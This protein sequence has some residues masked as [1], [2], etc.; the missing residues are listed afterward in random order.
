MSRII[1]LILMELSNDKVWFPDE[2]ESH[3]NDL[4]KE[5]YSSANYIPIPDHDK[6]DGG[7][8]GFSLDGHAYQMYCPEEVENVSKLYEKQR[9]KMT[10]D[11][12][13]FITN[14]DKM[15]GFFGDLKIK[16]WILVV[17]SHKTKDLVAHATKKTLEVKAANLDYVDNNDFRVLIWDRS[18]FKKEE[19][20]LLQAGYATLKL[21]ISDIEEH[22]VASF[23]EDTS[24]EFM[25]NLTTKLSK[26]NSTP[27][28][29]ANGKGLLTRKA[30][31]SQNMLTELKEDYPEFHKAITSTKDKRAEEIFIEALDSSPE[32]QSIAYQ[33]N[34]LRKKLENSAKL[35]EDNLDT[36]ALGTVADWLMNCTLDFH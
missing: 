11:I 10:R 29:V 21:N 24:T 26:L 28:V 12:G 1:E 7:I 23:I 32:S 15:S 30:I 35:H 3:A 16:R 8:E 27:S 19:T 2:W 14:A 31:M 5:R 33:K 13:K 22:H 17:P 4:L 20:M 9:N 34:V 18:E 36:I 25:S 6:G